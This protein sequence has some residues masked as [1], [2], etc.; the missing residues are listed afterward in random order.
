[1]PMLSPTRA[2]RY[3]SGRA[4]RF[5]LFSALAAVVIVAGFTTVVWLSR[6][7]S[8]IPLPQRR[9]L[10]CGLVAAYAGAVIFRPLAW[11]VID[12]AVLAG[13][14]GAVIWFERALQTPAAIVA[15]VTV[16]AVMD[17]ISMMS[18]GLTRVLV[19]HYQKGT[20]GL[21]MYL[22]L[23]APFHGST[24]PIIG[25]G[26]LFIG[27]CVAL[28]LIR[29][30]LRPAAVMSALLTVL[31]AALAIGL[32]RG[33]APAVPFL[34]LAVYFLLWRRAQRFARH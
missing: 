24:I 6:I 10:A 18:G 12:L 23:V 22:A 15:F 5:Y 30:K 3:S 7:A 19:E 31:L 2:M 4:M 25:I 9:L 14:I 13:A 20:S 32:W 34:A 21:L 33:G 16:A 8:R 29:L 28:G 1:M 17:F 11:P 26:D 27:G